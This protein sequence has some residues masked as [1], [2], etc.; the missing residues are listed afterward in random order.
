MH[1]Q[2]FD[3][4]NSG[5]DDEMSQVM[6]PIPPLHLDTNPVESEAPIPSSDQSISPTLE[7][8]HF[9]SDH[10]H[11]RSPSPL[12]TASEIGPSL[13][14]TSAPLLANP[15]LTDFLSNHPI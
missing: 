3:Y 4:S 5:T 13:L 6:L 1:Y 12:L 2:Q 8:P 15:S 7:L 14:G 10:E 11:A 9:F